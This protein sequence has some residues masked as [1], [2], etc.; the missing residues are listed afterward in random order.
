M[1]NA[2]RRTVT[3]LLCGGAFIAV[4][5][6]TGCSASRS[7]TQ[8]TAS[9][10][11]DRGPKPAAVA[12]GR[13]NA[14]FNTLFEN[15][16][17]PPSR[18]PAVNVFGE[19]NTKST[20]PTP[21]FQEASF[22]QHT[23]ADVGYDNDPS[24]SPDGKWLVFASTRHSEHSDIYL[25]RVDG[26]SVTQLTFDEADDAFPTFSSDGKQIAFC[27]TRAGSWDLYVMD[28]DGKN[29][30]QVTSGPMQD[31]HPSFSPDGKR[32]VYCASGGRSGRRG[33]VVVD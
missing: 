20:A 10:G 29:V 32:L 31:L 2:K 18:A 33:G 23:F 19:L 28:I 11:A 12:W 6:S 4:V 5:V 17:I 3:W 22:K 1:S 7:T 16:T 30:T 25:Q 13:P 8:P 21:Q 15:P 27:S 26:L 14:Q 24:V 9:K